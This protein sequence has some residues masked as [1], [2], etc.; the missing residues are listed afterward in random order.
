M[1]SG[2][3]TTLSETRD[4]AHSKEVEK[5]VSGVRPSQEMPS[6][7]ITGCLSW[8]SL[9]NLPLALQKVYKAKYEKEKGKSI[10]NQMTV[11]PDVQHA[12]DVAKKQS[13]VCHQPPCRVL[14]NPY[15]SHIIF[16]LS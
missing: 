11:P 15:D 10:Y 13:N 1:Q 4:T 12:I 2:S 5:L 14:E 6:K 7:Q 8:L 9:L 3:F 16:L